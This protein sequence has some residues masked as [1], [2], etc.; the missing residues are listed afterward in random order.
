MAF[1]AIKR[2]SQLVTAGL[3]RTINGWEAWGVNLG[4][5]DLFVDVQVKVFDARTGMIKF[6]H[7][8]LRNFLLP[9]NCST[10]FPSFATPGAQ[11]IN[12]KENVAAIYLV[13]GASVL[14]RH[15]N[16][17]EPLKEVPFNHSTSLAAKIYVEGKETWL[18]L[19]SRVPVKGVLV[20]ALGVGV[21]EVFWDENGV[22]L[23]PL[24]KMRLP[25]RGLKLGDESR[26]SIRWLGGELGNG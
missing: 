3:K 7:V 26:L 2:E 11:E 8:L 6:E 21:D 17:H 23:V 13:Q 12:D 16:F 4:L 25:V 5:E 15:V 18:E 9:A 24:E 20:Q 22:D 1:W 19:E 10:E 14:V